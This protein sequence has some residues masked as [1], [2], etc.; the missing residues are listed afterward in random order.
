MPIGLQPC[1]SALLDSTPPMNFVVLFSLVPVLLLVAVGFAASKAQWL[2][3]G[4]VK[5]LST[6]LF[7]VLTPALMFRTMSRVH[8]TSWI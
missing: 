8:L 4:S 6:L 3:P 2:K 1:A 7:M 5:D